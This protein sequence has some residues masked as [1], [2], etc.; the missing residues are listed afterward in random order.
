MDSTFL[1]QGSY[2]CVY[3]QKLRC[4]K[5]N[6]R[7]QKKLDILSKIYTDKKNASQ[8]LEISKYIKK[9]PHYDRHFSPLLDSCNAS[10]AQINQDDI[11]K[12]DL[13]E[14]DPSNDPKYFTTMTKFIK[15]QTLDKYMDKYMKSNY[16]NVNKI[17]Y[18]HT[19]LMKSIELLNSHGI[20]HF[21]LNSS[22]I[23]MDTT[24]RPIIIDYGMSIK[25][26][27]IK[28]QED[29]A[30]AFF[31]YPITEPYEP[32]IIEIAFLC[33]LSQTTD[34]AEELTELN[35]DEM[36]EL[37]DKY[38][39]AI[40]LEETGMTSD[41]IEEYKKSKREL[42]R[43]FKGEKAGKCA[44][45]LLK[46]HMLWDKYAITLFCLKQG[47]GTKVPLRSLLF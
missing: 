33:Y 17:I 21:D 12:C 9:I 13:F 31:Y 7:F 24:D 8:E 16:A 34:F 3:K 10:L 41:Q 45:E 47:K 22:N 14:N 38:I 2:G 11:D 37:S 26:D 42:C 28:T 32:W 43:S 29:Y 15:G 35:I 6:P 5:K 40:K 36:T 39:D 18:I 27:K 1:G 20:V 23:I 4:M 25:I 46:T 30:S 44:E 19:Y